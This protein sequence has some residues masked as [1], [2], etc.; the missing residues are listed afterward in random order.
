MH[1]LRLMRLE[2][3]SRS[4]FEQ[5]PLTRTVSIVLSEEFHCALGL[6]PRFFRSTGGGVTLGKFFME[7]RCFDSR[8]RC[9]SDR[10]LQLSRRLVDTAERAQGLADRIARDFALVGLLRIFRTHRERLFERVESAVEG[11]GLVARPTDVIQEGREPVAAWTVVGQL[12]PTSGPCLHVSDKGSHVSGVACQE[13]V[14]CGAGLLEGSFKERESAR[15]VSA[16]PQEPSSL[17]EYPALGP[18]ECLGLGEQA[19]AR[20]EVA[21]KSLNSRQLSEKGSSARCGPFLLDGRPESSPAEI[22]VVEIP[23]VTPANGP[24]LWHR[25]HPPE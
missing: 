14:V 7:I 17:D 10:E 22:K 23:H 15:P 25:A 11:S 2:T 19:L 12:D 3:R 24:P 18:A 13:S 8:I 9:P 21:A 4:G 20:S 1:S 16:R 5:P 6:N